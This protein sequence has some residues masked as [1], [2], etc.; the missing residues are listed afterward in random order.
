MEKSARVNYLSRGLRGESTRIGTDTVDSLPAGAADTVF[1][2]AGSGFVSTVFLTIK[3]ANAEKCADARIRIFSGGRGHADIDQPIRDF[4]MSGREGKD[5]VADYMGKCRSRNGEE[6]SLYRNIFVPYRSGLRIEIDNTTEYC[7]G[8][9]CSIQYTVTSGPVDYGRFSRALGTS[10]SSR[11]RSWGEEIVLVDVEGRGCFHSFQLSMRNKDTPGQFME[12]NVQIFLDDNEFPEYQSTGTEEFFMGGVYFTNLHTSA[13]SSCTRTFNDGSENPEHVISAQRFFIDDVLFFNRR[14][15]IVWHCGQPNQG[16]V[17]GSTYFDFAGIHYID[18][19]DGCAVK[20]LDTGEAQSILSIVDGDA[21]DLP[22]AAKSFDMSAECG[23]TELLRLEGTG[24]LETLY[25]SCEDASSLEKAELFLEIDGRKTD[26]IPFEWFFL[27]DY[28]ASGCTTGN[29]GKTV[30]GTFYRHCDIQYAQSLRLVVSLGTVCMIQGYAEYREGR[31][32]VFYDYNIKILTCG[33][34]SSRLTDLADGNK[35]G[36][37]EAVFIS[38]ED[39]TQPSY[40]EIVKNDGEPLAVENLRSF[41]LQPGESSSRKGAVSD[42]SI[43]DDENGKFIACRFFGTSRFSFSGGMK[44]RVVRKDAYPLKLAFFYKTLARSDSEIDATATEVT[45]RL[46]RVDFAGDMYETR[47]YN[48][49]E[50]F[51]GSIEAGQ[52]AVMFE[53]FDAGMIK[54]IRFGTPHVG[55]ALHDSRFRLYLDRSEVPSVDTTTGRFFSAEYDD[56]IF[57]SGTRSL[58]RVSKRGG[59]NPENE[60]QHSSFFRYINIPYHDGAKL[61]LT[62]P[63]NSRIHGFDNV[64]YASARAGGERFGLFDHTFCHSRELTLGAGETAELATCDGQTAIT[65]LQFMFESP[66]SAD[67]LDSILYIAAESMTKV[68]IETSLYRYFFGPNP[69]SGTHCVSIQYGD[70]WRKIQEKEEAFYS[71][72]E[73]GWIRRGIHSPFRNVMYRLLENRPI[74]LTGKSAIRITNRS[75]STMKIYSDIMTRTTTNTHPVL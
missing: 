32:R 23:E 48:P 31:R 46:N 30:E 28:G 20:A 58:A 66:T 16:A 5:T 19:L 60:L 55:T 12:G 24:T 1:A 29:A 18:E 63:E 4:F 51:T 43:L 17:L 11:S 22:V 69:K 68:L 35:N 21:F 74:L 8:L 45:M 71:S 54:C 2:C 3:S 73:H 42:L 61:T 56:P 9:D 14:L 7:F 44:T 38:A 72:P 15:K 75:L 64:Y 52:T 41:F 59:D 36:L 25:L 26:S 33:E 47:C 65:S 39:L 34:K 62:A 70:S 50:S 37:L 40:I 27:N 10:I 49:I 67:Y 57:W 53:D 13:F 6:T